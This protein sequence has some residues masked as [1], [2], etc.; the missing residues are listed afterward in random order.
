[1]KMSFERVKPSIS[2][3]YFQVVFDDGREEPNDYELSH[4][5]F[6]LSADCEG[7][8][9]DTCY[10]ETLNLDTIGHYRILKAELGRNR[11][12]LN[13]AR[14]QAVRFEI[15]FKASDSEYAQLKDVLGRM[16]P[17][18]RVVGTAGGAPESG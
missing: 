12:L 17:H 3:D 2:G 7:P 18:L 6:L 13:G 4:P 14:E 15:C 9:A 16:I 5:Y 1:M 8:D 11:L 10:V